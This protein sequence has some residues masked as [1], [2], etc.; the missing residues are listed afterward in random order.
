MTKFITK[1]YAAREE[2]ATPYAAGLLFE[3]EGFK[4]IE[5]TDAKNQA[6]YIVA[7]LNVDS[8]NPIYYELE[9]LDFYNLCAYYLQGLQ[10]GKKH[11]RDTLREEL[12]ILVG[13]RK[14]LL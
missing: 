3:F 8:K 13:K 11:A 6:R 12:E 14:G 10:P 5:G 7:D 1:F 4:F 2:E 9:L